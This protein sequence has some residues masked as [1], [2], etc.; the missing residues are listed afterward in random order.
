MGFGFVQ[1]TLKGVTQ[2]VN[3]PSGVGT[4]PRCSAGDPALPREG[5]LGLAP[6]Q[7][8]SLRYLQPSILCPLAEEVIEFA[9]RSRVSKTVERSRL[10]YTAR[11][12]D[13]SAPGDTCQCTAD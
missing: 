2:A 8:N 11:G 13:E 1:T 7:T 3:L 10:G 6:S 4:R 5:P 12:A 9:E